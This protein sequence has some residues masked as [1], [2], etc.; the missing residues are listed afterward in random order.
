M[1]V[2]IWYMT[3]FKIT[4]YNQEYLSTP[5]PV[6]EYLFLDYLEHPEFSDISVKYKDV[7]R[8]QKVDDEIKAIRGVFEDLGY[9][10]QDI[11]SIRKEYMEKF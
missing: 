6:M 10:E 7:R 4:P 8:K 3:H 2:R 1:E 11:R 5:F 9:N